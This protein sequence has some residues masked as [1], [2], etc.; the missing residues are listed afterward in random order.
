MGPEK[1]GKYCLMKCLKDY[2]FFSFLF[3]LSGKK[4]GKERRNGLCS[5]YQNG[6][7]GDV[8]VVKYGTRERVQTW[9]NLKRDDGGCAFI[10]GGESPNE[11]LG[12]FSLL[13]K[14]K[15]LFPL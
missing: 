1:F 4:E 5:K 7:F 8:E 14:H 12:F 10:V 13:N 3:L 11:R 15:Y 9:G 6:G 2:N